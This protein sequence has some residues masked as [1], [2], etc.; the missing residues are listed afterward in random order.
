M[1]INTQYTQND[2]SNKDDIKTPVHKDSL[3]LLASLITF[4]TGLIRSAIDIIL[5]LYLSNHTNSTEVEIG[6]IFLVF[7]CSDTGS[8]LLITVFSSHLT[9]H[10][11]KYIILVTGLM[12]SVTAIVLLT[13]DTYNGMLITC[14]LL[15]LSFGAT[16]LPSNVI[17]MRCNELNGDSEMSMSIMNLMWYGDF[18]LGNFCGGIPSTDDA[19]YQQVILN[20]FS[21][22]SFAI[23]A[24]YF[25]KK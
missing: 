15:G 25:S 11:I 12:M 10:N 24:V 9:K 3:I 17:L 1:N 4:G 16:G 5:P 20:I 6:I 13:P 8:S 7:S 19:Y 18:A 23:I 21:I 2:I 14:S 22:V